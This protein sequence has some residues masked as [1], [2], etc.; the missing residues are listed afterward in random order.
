MS[1]LQDVRV[2]LIEDE[3]SDAYLVIETLKQ[4]HDV[5]FEVTWVESIAQAKQTL[6]G[7]NID[8]MLL[9]LS[10]HHSDGLDTVKAAQEIADD[11]PIVVLTGHNEVKFALSALKMGVADYAPKEMLNLSGDNL[12]RVIR[13]TLLRVEIET[14][15]RLL[16][17]ANLDLDVLRKLNK[18]AIFSETDLNGR[19]ISVNEKFCILCGYSPTELIGKTHNVLFSGIHSKEFYLNLW[20]TIKRGKVWTG[21]ICN[22]KKN[23][24]PYWINAVILPICH[25]NGVQSYKYAM[26]AFDITDKKRYEQ[27]MK[28]RVALYEAAVETTDGFC[29]VNRSGNFLEV[30]EGYCHLSGYSREEFLSMNIL[31]MHENF[32]LDEQQF[33]HLVDN[34]GKTFEVEQMRKNGTIF[35]AE[36]T[37]AYS[38]LNDGSLFVFL[39]DITERVELQKRE[40]LLSRQLMHMQKIDSI[41]R[42]TAGIAHDFNNI[43]ASIL[44]YNELSKMVSED[45]PDGDL[46]NGLIVYTNQID[47]SGKRAA[48]LISKMM[49][50]CRQHI[51][52]KEVD[53]SKSTR[54]TIEEIVEMVR[55]GLTKDI[56]IKLELS[57]D[58]NILIHATDL[59]QILTNL[60][61]NARD[62]M[63]V[64]HSVIN[65]KL[66]TVNILTHQCSACLRAIAGDFIELSVSDN[67]SGIDEKIIE[68]VF[69]PF[70]TTKSVGLGTGLGLSAVSGIVHHANGHILID[71]QLDVGT[72]FRLLFPIEEISHE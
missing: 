59:H 9:D 68:N 43:L 20:T 6:I 55:V 31:T 38:T 71:S 25:E 54:H 33:E 5:H 44:G 64:P 7:G 57:D 21:E 24:E 63:K 65:V 47:V 18:S 69:D 37:A 41:G 17:A 61:V 23:R 34:H 72:T 39:H 19:I 2:L 26:V 3:K 27:T 22:H 15:K 53:R 40:A 8:V 30:S 50:Y 70:F 32:G 51:V 4:S 52:S 16:A 12:A 48:D 58:A 29:H 14:N 49:T 46:K 56:E 13:Y 10:L 35:L 66:K 62:A 45:M 60:L 36:I 28:N 42:L 1:E 67:G 11:I